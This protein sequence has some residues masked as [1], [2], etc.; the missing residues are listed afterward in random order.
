[1]TDS[2]RVSRT[3]NSR[4]TNQSFKTC[5]KKNS[6]KPSGRTDRFDKSV[7]GESTPRSKYEI[8]KKIGNDSHAPSGGGVLGF[9]VD[10]DRCTTARN[11]D[12]PDNVVDDGACGGRWL[13][14]SGS[15]Y[16]MEDSGGGSRNYDV[17]GSGGSSSSSGGCFFEG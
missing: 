16:F 7:K 14:N 9:P 1:M 13:Y 8:M 5:G 3:Q 12:N 11:E 4:F 15:A 10:N 2:F 17:C 6:S